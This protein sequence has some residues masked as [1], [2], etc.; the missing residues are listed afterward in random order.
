M[1]KRE[2][3]YD[4]RLDDLPFEGDAAAFS[5]YIAEVRSPSIK[6]DVTSDFVLT[7]LND[8]QK[9]AVQEL[10][11]TAKFTRAQFY[12]MAERAIKWNWNIIKDEKGKEIG[13][14]TKRNLSDDEKKVIRAQGD[15][16]HDSIMTQLSTLAI[17]NRNDERNYMLKKLIEKT[18]SND[19][20]SFEERLVN[21]AKGEERKEKK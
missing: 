9:E 11:S 7:V 14:W 13:T 16:V 18:A 12:T 3:G 2:I 10:V 5:K 8:A 15:I 21:Y 20:M 4:G 1:M 6:D 17:L 19:E